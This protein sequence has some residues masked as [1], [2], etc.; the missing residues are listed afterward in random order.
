MANNA[1]FDRRFG[2][3]IAGLE[4]ADDI[5]GRG[6][7]RL[8]ENT[9]VDPGLVRTL[10]ALALSSP[11]KSD[12]QQRD[13][14]IVQNPDL[15]LRINALFPNMPWVADAPAFL[16]FLGNNRRQRQIHEW[17]G[18]PFANDHL[19]A[20]FNAT[21]DAGIALSAF[22]MTAER[23]GLGCCPIS[24]IR[25]HA[26]E[27]SDWFQLPDYVFPVAGLTLG[28]PARPTRVSPRLPLSVTVHTDHFDE[29][30]VRAKIE[31][32]DAR[33]AAIQPYGGQRNVERFGTTEP[34]TWSEEKARHYASP[35]R[36]DFGAFIRAK[37]FKLD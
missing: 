7:C 12:L 16:V 36:T 13:I 30:D 32:Y 23:A 8:Y 26:A 35:E 19:D 24:V 34:Y 31:A 37:G 2:E 20:F 9:P 6:V 29:T 5:T 21:V 17:R 22:V 4:G 25:D 10:C 15:R 11:T 3:D 14:L 33:R 1:S 28:Y 18:H 27:V